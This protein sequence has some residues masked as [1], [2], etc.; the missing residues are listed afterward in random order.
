M[1]LTAVVSIPV[2]VVVAF[3]VAWVYSLLYDQVGDGLSKSSHD[4]SDMLTGGSGGDQGAE[5]Q[6]RDS[7]TLTRT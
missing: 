5:L 6:V 3:V 4:L 7:L 1:V 2:F